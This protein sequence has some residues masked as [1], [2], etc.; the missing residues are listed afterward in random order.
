LPHCATPQSAG[1][2]H[3]V[4]PP[5]QQ[6]S[7][8]TDGQSDGQLQAVSLAQHAPLPHT[9]PW[10]SAGQVHV[11]S[12]APQQPSPHRSMP[13]Q[14]PAEQRPPL[15][16][17]PVGTHGAVL[18]AC[19]HPPAAALHVSS[20]QGFPSSQLGG[21]PPTHTREAQW[22]AVVHGLPS[23]QAAVLATNTQPCTGSQWSS[24]QT[25]PSLQT[26]GVPWQTPLWQ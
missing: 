4:S 10:Q 7:P 20:V 25:F 6:P 5:V 14:R 9:S 1:Q 22:S 13:T 19:T 15:A 3:T 11:L 23:S 21:G 17:G 24:V 26:T 12:V 2:L 16:Q 8:Q 18:N